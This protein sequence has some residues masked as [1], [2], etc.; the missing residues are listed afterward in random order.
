[1]SFG[2]RIGIGYSGLSYSSSHI[3]NREGHVQEMVSGIAAGFEFDFWLS[4]MFAIAPHLLYIER[5]GDRRYTDFGGTDDQTISSV[6]YFEI[7][8]YA[9]FQI[10][11]RSFRPYVF[12]GPAVGLLVSG[13]EK[14][15]KL[16][17]QTGVRG[18]E[19]F[20]SSDFYANVGF[21]I[22]YRLDDE[23]EAIL[24]GTYSLGLS[25]VISDEYVKAK[26]VNI[27]MMAG[28]LFRM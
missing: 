25:D 10:G 3:L 21:G 24:D 2:P 27:R 20:R 7:P 1:M 14:S 18:K 28:M 23:I 4:D 17:T 11:S 6:N 16:G 26:S 13:G 12:A 22:S 15:Y 5:G 9:K 8:I 19:S